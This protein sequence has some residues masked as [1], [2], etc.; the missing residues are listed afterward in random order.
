[1]GV[2]GAIWVLAGRV[3][4]GPAYDAV[5][6]AVFLG[7]KMSMIMA[8]APVILPAVL[9]CRLPYHP[10]MI[11]APVLL[12]A[13]LLLRLTVGDARGLETALQIGGGLNFIAMLGFAVLTAS[14]AIR[15]GR[16]RKAATA[17]SKAVANA[18]TA[19]TPSAPS[20][21]WPERVAAP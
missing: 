3:T 5:I 10:V 4:E 13:S 11:A 20:G 2:A 19:A 12:H 21:P 14:A 1:M 15:A 17:T 9:G 7:F 18:V 6:H 8:H 16:S